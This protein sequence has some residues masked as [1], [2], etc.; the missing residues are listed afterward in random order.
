MKCEFRIDCKKETEPAAAASFQLSMAVYTAMRA[1]KAESP[2]PLVL[3]TFDGFKNEGKTI[4]FESS[5]IKQQPPAPRVT[6]MFW[7]RYK[8][9]D[10]NQKKEGRALMFVAAITASPRR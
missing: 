2:A 3:R 1:P 7:R 9:L 4:G 6:K 5:D 10:T 8:T